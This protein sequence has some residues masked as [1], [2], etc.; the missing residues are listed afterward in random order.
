MTLLILF[1]QAE[2]VEAY[3]YTLLGLEITVAI[4]T[5]LLVAWQDFSKM[6]EP[7]DKEKKRFNWKTMWWRYR[8][9]NVIIMWISGAIG[10]FVSGEI[11]MPLITKYLDYPGLTEDTIDLFGVFI[12]TFLFAKY[13]SK[14]F[15]FQPPA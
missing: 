9:D 4:L 13:I 12:V 5:L 3:D 7:Y 15:G 11:A 14:L 8:N 2:Q 1:F 6:K 10:A